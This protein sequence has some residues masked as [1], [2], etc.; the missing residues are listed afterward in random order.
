LAAS[1]QFQPDTIYAT[2]GTQVMRS[3]DGGCGWEQIFDA[4]NAP[5]AALG[6]LPQTATITSLAAPSSANSSR[7][8]YVGVD[9]T[10]AGVKQPLVAASA[11]E[12]RTWPYATSSNGLPPVGHISDLS[13]TADLPLASYALVTSSVGGTNVDRQVYASSDG[14]QTWAARTPLGA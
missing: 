4:T 13:A 11:K 14:G 12:G 7:Y 8:L 3:M 9:A 6:V 1:P 2:N 10:I 5:S